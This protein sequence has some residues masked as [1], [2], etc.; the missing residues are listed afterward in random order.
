MDLHV[1]VPSVPV[2]ALLKRTAG[3]DESQIQANI[4]AA[5]AQQIARAGKLNRELDV[6][7]VERFCAPDEAANAFLA[8]AAGRLGLSARGL[9]R[10]LRVA[11]TIADLANDPTVGLTHISEAI[12]YRK[13]DRQRE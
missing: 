9:H 4:E 12:S 3:D 13:L 7:E 10:V 1:D 6:R 2:N 8:N 11:R 5:V